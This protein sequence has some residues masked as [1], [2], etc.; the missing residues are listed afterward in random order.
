MSSEPFTPDAIAPAAVHETI[1]VSHEEAEQIVDSI[2]DLRERV[3][4]KQEAQQQESVETS[5]AASGLRAALR[6]AFGGT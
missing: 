1:A 2:R 4:H 6:N 5:P 3:Q